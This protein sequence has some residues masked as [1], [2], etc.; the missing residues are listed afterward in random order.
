MSKG[1]EIIFTNAA[2]ACLSDIAYHH[3]HTWSARLIDFMHEFPHSCESILSTIL[4]L[5]KHFNGTGIAN[6]V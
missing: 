2:S 6:Y 4:Y 3:F 5:I 1:Q